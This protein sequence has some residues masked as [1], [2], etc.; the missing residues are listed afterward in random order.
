MDPTTKKVKQKLQSFN[1]E[2]YEA[3]AKE[4]DHL[5]MERFFQEAHYLEWLSNVVLVKKASRKWRMCINFTNLNKACSKDSFALPH[6][7]LIA[8]STMGHPLLN[9]LDAYSG[10]NHI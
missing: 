2:K 1:V 4:V 5:L 6:I 3:I 8:D 7:D 10:Y 9:F